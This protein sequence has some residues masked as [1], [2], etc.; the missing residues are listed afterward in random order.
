VLVKIGDVKD[1]AVLDAEGGRGRAVL[2]VHRRRH[3]ER[4]VETCERDLLVIVEAL[5][6]Q[7]RDRVLVHRVLDGVS[8]RGIDSR[9]EIDADKFGGE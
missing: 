6:G 1:V 3:F 2:A 5:A 8:R 4:A 7:H 9:S